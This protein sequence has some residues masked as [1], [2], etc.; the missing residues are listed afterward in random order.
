MTC[1]VLL[2]SEQGGLR[3]CS[4]KVEG[5][6]W[7]PD[8]D[9]VLCAFYK[10]SFVEVSGLLPGRGGLSSR[11]HSLAIKMGISSE[12]WSLLPTL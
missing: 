5:M 7:A 1:L 11:R 12:P 10:R 3:P 4:D 8:S 9:L 2:C 6:E